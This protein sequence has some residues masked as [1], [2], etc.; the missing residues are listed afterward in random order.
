MNCW[1]GEAKAHE[2]RGDLAKAV[3]EV[4]YGMRFIRLLADGDT[5]LASQSKQ[6]IHPDVKVSQLSAYAHE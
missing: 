6:R 5:A 3:V 4:L 2:L 1:H